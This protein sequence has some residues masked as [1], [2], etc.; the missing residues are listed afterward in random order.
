M[1][2]EIK[3]TR[4]SAKTNVGKLPESCFS[5]LLSSSEIIK[6]EAGQSGYTKLTQPAG[7]E[8]MTPNDKEK[9][10]DDLNRE[11]GVTAGQ[12]SAMDAGSMFGWGVAG[13]N[14]DNYNYDGTFKTVNAEV[15]R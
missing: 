3:L 12:R 10:I 15:V 4:E 1:K 9:F 5:K 8:Q 14:P 2:N 11:D 7:Y 13:A 6:I